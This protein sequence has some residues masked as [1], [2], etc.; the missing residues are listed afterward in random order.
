M[1]SPENDRVLQL[2]QIMADWD[3]EKMKVFFENI[4]KIK[5]EEVGGENKKTEGSPNGQGN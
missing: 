3:A 5:R 2:A 1:T 4:D